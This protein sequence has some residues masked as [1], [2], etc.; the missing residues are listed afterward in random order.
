MDD[1]AHICLAHHAHILKQAVNDLHERWNIKRNLNKDTAEGQPHH[2]FTWY[3]VEI[4]LRTGILTIPERKRYKYLLKVLEAIDSLQ[5]SRKFLQ[6]LHGMLCWASL[7]IIPVRSFLFEIRALLALDTPFLNITEEVIYELDFWRRTLQNASSIFNVAIWDR[8]SLP[9]ST[10]AA[11][12]EGFG[13]A[14]YVNRILYICSAPFPEVLKAEARFLH[15]VGMLEFLAVYAA[16]STF[17]E[18][19]RGKHILVHTDSMSTLA[20]INAKAARKDKAT[21]ILLRKLLIL[22]S[23]LNCSIQAIHIK[24]ESNI[25]ADMLS[26]KGSIYTKEVCNRWLPA[27]QVQVV[28]VA[29]SCLAH[30]EQ[31]YRAE[32]Q[33]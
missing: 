6:K 19:L 26:R 20:T 21:A 5:V 11:P 12:S 28:E 17:R 2:T 4:N 33:A 29:A 10:D 7:V 8:Q 32:S 14:I 23:Q 9:L 31:A 25:L 16:I 13:A 27:I 18:H 30:M 1:S 15:K 24:G 22:V 3:G